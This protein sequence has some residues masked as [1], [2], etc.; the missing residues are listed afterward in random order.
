MTPA[1]PSIRN[2]HVPRTEHSEKAAMGALYNELAK[3][4]ESL[5]NGDVYTLDEA[6]EEVD[7]I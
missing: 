3:G 4:I 1:A 6:W 7:R 5:K 2:D